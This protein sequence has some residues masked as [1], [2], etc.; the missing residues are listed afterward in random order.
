MEQLVNGVALDVGTNFETNFAFNRMRAGQ[1][2]GV[3]LA[4]TQMRFVFLICGDHRK[5]ADFAEQPRQLRQL[6][7]VNDM[8][9]VSDHC[10]SRAVIYHITN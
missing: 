9:V 10:D 5:L 2:V 3:N 1:V 6:V 4:L 7:E 8:L